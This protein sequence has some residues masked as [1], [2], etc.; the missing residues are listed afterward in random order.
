MERSAASLG[1]A[2]VVQRPDDVLSID[3]IV[4]W[5]EVSHFPAKHGEGR[6]GDFPP[7]LSGLPRGLQRKRRIRSYRPRR[8]P[9]CSSS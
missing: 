6:D 9:E 1:F 8:S 4:L 2:L 5:P 3:E 7:H